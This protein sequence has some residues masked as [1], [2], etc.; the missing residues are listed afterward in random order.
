MK[1][2]SGESSVVCLYQ[3][4]TVGVLSLMTSGP[5]NE[6]S[7]LTSSDQ[8]ISHWTVG[9]SGHYPLYCVLTH[10]SWSCM[11]CLVGYLEVLDYILHS[12]QFYT[13]Q[14]QMSAGVFSFRPHTST[15]P[16]DYY[17]IQEN[18]IIII[19]FKKCFVQE[20]NLT[21]KFN[22]VYDLSYYQRSTSSNYTI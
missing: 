7:A 8:D 21:L 6:R 16:T 3:N 11:R 22:F 12:W 14:T 15:M 4:P 13:L 2:E 5:T 9:H 10:V 19:R 20:M 17:L 1:E 18:V